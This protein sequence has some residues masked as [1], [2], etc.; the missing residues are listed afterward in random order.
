MRKFIFILFI[1]YCLVF[2]LYCQDSIYVNCDKSSKIFVGEISFF[3]KKRLKLTKGRFDT[4][5][6]FND[7]VKIAISEASSKKITERNRVRNMND[8]PSIDDI[9]NQDVVNTFLQS[10]KKD[11]TIVEKSYLDCTKHKAKREKWF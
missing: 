7:V 5:I 8:V 4:I 3:N 6:L 9:V 11:K 2:N 1:S 10:A